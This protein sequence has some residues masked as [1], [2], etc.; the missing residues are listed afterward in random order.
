MIIDIK[1]YE[2]LCGLP[3]DFTYLDNDGNSHTYKKFKTK[4]KEVPE[5]ILKKHRENSLYW[6]DK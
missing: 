6:F 1:K 4:Y 3:D 2:H 5:H